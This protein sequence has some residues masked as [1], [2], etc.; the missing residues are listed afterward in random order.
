[1]TKQDLRNKFDREKDMNWE[2]SQGEPEIEYV[3]WLEEIIL[4]QTC[5]HTT[6]RMDGTCDDCG[7]C[8][9]Y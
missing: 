9:A 5:Q 6:I 3:W 1:M 8:L 2:N 4:R 7:I